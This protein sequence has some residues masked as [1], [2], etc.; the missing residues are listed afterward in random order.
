MSKDKDESSLAD[1]AGG[2]EEWQEWLHNV[3]QPWAGAAGLLEY[4]TLPENEEEYDEVASPT[5]KATAGSTADKLKREAEMRRIWAVDVQVGSA[6]HK[7]FKGSRVAMLTGHAS[8]RYRGSF[9]VR[10]AEKHF[11]KSTELAIAKA[12]ARLEAVRPDHSLSD[13]EC[14]AQWWSDT[15]A[16]YN[17]FERLCKAHNSD[18]LY[19]ASL[20]PASHEGFEDSVDRECRKEVDEEPRV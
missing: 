4:G 5:P 1:F 7:A 6:I 19:S 11:S 20:A 9:I 12:Q 8:D 13:D 18:E 16:S 10:R 17:E 3:L 14:I 15:V 2:A